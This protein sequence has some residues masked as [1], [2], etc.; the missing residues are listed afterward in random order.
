[1]GLDWDAMT[2]T[3]REGRLGYRGTGAKGGRVRGRLSLILLESV[4]EYGRSVR[5]GLISFQ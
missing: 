5:P 3:A 2:A 4:F 1:M